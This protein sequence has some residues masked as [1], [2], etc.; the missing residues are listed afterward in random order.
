MSAG[1]C[2]SVR[3][4]ADIEIGCRFDST[5]GL[6][7][8]GKVDAK[9]IQRNSQHQ[10]YIQSFAFISHKHEKCLTWVITG[11]HHLLPDVLCAVLVCVCGLETQRL[12]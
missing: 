3:D 8:W 6:I 10:P 11:R 12:E 2:Q 5:P 9:L 7:C 4:G 1:V